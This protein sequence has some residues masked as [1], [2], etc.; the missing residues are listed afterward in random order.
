MITSYNEILNKMKAA[1]FERCGER[2]TELS[3]TSARLEAAASELFSI[4]CSAQYVLRRAFPQ[5]ADSEYL[6]YHAA[7][8]DITR[9][10]PSK[11]SGEL[12]FFVNAPAERRLEIPSGTICSK[13][14]EP[15]VQFETLEACAVAEGET[16]A[17]VRAR[18]LE[19]GGEHN[20]PQNTVSVMVNAP[21]GI[22]GVYNASAFT[23]GA[24]AESDTALR[25]RIL[26]SYSIPQTGFSL[27]ALRTALLKNRELLDCKVSYDSGEVV[28]A[29]RLKDGAVFGAVEE[30]IREA[31]AVTELFGCTLSVVE[32]RETGFS[33]TVE[34]KA[35][36]T[37]REELQERIKASIKEYLSSVNIGEDILLNRLVYCAAALDGVSYC[38][39][40]SPEAV[41][42]RLLC[43]D[44]AYLSLNE[45][46]VSC[47]E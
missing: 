25:K 47:Y 22:D 32:A 39:V 14:N 34:A 26:S 29:V 36:T 6:D 16:E 20:A 44:G 37:D 15:Y 4:A 43:P 10:E 19:A 28:V 7:L 27:E 38:E 12:T 1:F 35:Q 2:V 8:R 9:K 21:S 13:A 33:L 11:A 24:D 40:S 23:G 42:G 46:R 41:Q 17:T 45:I 18:A 30:E 5:T 3:D 31:I